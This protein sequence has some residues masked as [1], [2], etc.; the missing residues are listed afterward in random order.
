MKYAHGP[1]LPYRGHVFACWICLKGYH[2]PFPVSTTFVRGLQYLH[3]S[4]WKM[5]IDG[6]SGGG[7]G[8][9]GT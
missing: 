5:A 1:S 8:G 2:L 7:R 6:G 4:K 3:W 9:S